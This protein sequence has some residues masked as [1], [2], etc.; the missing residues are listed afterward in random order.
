MIAFSKG[1][2]HFNV[3]D[4]IYYIINTKSKDFIIV[5]LMNSEIQIS[6]DNSNYIDTND[7]I[8]ETLELKVVEDEQDYY[9]HNGDT[10][11]GVIDEN[12]KKLYY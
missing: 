9:H 3:G 7:I 1:C 12:D 4:F 6:D 2:S 8:D 10:I 5:T 11:S